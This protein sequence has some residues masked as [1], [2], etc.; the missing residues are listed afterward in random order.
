MVLLVILTAAAVA[1]Y[2]VFTYTH[3][4]QYV[5][6]SDGNGH[7]HL[8]YFGDMDIS[9]IDAFLPHQGMK[10]CWYVS[11]FSDHWQ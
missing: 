5:G 11:F 10:P 1:D 7:Y 4:K 8:A 2:A 3:V 9:C 6:V